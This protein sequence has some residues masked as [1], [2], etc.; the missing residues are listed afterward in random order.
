[1]WEICQLS[2]MQE[3]RPYSH[4][5]VLC[6]WL[7]FFLEK[8]IILHVMALVTLLCL[9]FACMFCFYLNIN[10]IFE[11]RTNS[12]NLQGSVSKESEM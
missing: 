3:T 9:S 7:L 11:F 1:M 5:A 4:T 10:R 8:L 6:S 12:W 2:Q